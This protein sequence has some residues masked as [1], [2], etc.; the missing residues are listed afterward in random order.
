M[1]AC[2]TIRTMGRRAHVDIWSTTT[3]ARER[4]D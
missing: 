4:T 3:Y 1:S 2:R